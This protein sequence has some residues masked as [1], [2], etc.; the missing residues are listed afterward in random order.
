MLATCKLC[1]R[2][3]HLRNS[4][5]LPEFLYD[6][7]Y[8]S[9]HRTFEVHGEQPDKPIYLQKG[10]REY[11]LCDECEQRFSLL[12]SYAA[13][14]IREI[15]SLQLASDRVSFQTVTVDYTRFKLFQMSLLWRSS[16]SSQDLFSKVDLGGS[17]EECLRQ[18][19]LEERPGNPH[20]F[21]CVM[22]MLPNTM[23]LKRMIWSPSIDYIDGRLCIR[24]I[25]GSIIWFFAIIP[26]PEDHAIQKLFL[27]RD[28]TLRVLLSPWSEDDLLEE[29][30]R[31]M[32]GL[33]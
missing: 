22:F 8:D 10:I 12:E 2:K 5:I 23:H 17:L 6:D 7:V 25:T 24:L 26:F 28:G 9:K 32:R 14:I 11:L 19:L 13:P 18:F 4:H 1:L 33:A 27:P 30:V 3:R 20:N 15:P 29:I 16:I 31:T 21:G